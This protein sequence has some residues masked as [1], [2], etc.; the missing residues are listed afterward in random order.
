MIPLVYD[1]INRC[2]KDAEFFSTLLRNLNVHN[3]AGLGRDGYLQRKK[4]LFFMTVFLNEQ[5]NLIFPLQ[6]P[7][8]HN[9]MNDNI[10]SYTVFRL[11]SFK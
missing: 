9:V 10:R 1:Q 2:G 11:R 4:L 3:I 8:H 7:G 6:Y 5:L